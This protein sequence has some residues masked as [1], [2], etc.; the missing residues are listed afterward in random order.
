MNQHSAANPKASEQFCE[1]PNIPPVATALYDDD[2]IENL[3]DIIA[4]LKPQEAGMLEKYLEKN[5]I[6]TL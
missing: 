4:A 1:P 2:P 3:G 5:G 6:K